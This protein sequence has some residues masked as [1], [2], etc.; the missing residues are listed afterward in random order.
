MNIKRTSKGFAH[1]S[2]LLLVLVVAVVA[3]AGYKVVK[4]RQVKT[5]ANQTSTAI[6][7]SAGQIKNTADLD[8]AANTINSQNVDGD[9][10]PNDLNGDVNALL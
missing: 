9:L 8:N 6:I 10:N 2:L 3:F 4:N 1:L 5:T 7:Q